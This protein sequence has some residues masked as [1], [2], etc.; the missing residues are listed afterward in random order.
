MAFFSALL[1]NKNLFGSLVQTFADVGNLVT[2][3]ARVDELREIS[4]ADMKN[5]GGAHGGISVGPDGA[6]HQAMEEPDGEERAG[7]REQAWKI[8]QIHIKI[9]GHFDPVDDH[10][11]NRR[12]GDEHARR[13]RHR[14]AR[15]AREEAGM[16]AGLVGGILTVLGFAALLA[17]FRVFGR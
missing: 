17:V 12:G 9:I 2:G 11:E 3:K 13:P 6:S 8:K 15:R 4:V 10:K 14:A 7:D 1:N 16:N 5:I